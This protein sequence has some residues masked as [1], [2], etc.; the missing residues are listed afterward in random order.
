M[1]VDAC[2]RFIDLV[3]KVD[4]RYNVF[5]KLADVKNNI[6][7]KKDMNEVKVNIANIVYN[8]L[9]ERFYNGQDIKIIIDK[10]K[11]HKKDLSLLLVGPVGSTILGYKVI[12]SIL[13][14]NL[15]VDEYYKKFIKLCDKQGLLDKILNDINYV[16]ND[17]ELANLMKNYKRM[18]NIDLIEIL[19]CK[20]SQVNIKYKNN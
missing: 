12:K 17:E 18:N 10:Q 9:L 16:P 14:N 6:K 8:E 7:L 3:I 4:E 20:Y 5:S 2:E 19:H 1:V 15:N 13:D 11:L